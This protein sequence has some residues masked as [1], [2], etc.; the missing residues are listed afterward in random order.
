MSEYLA[1]INSDNGLVP[2]RCQPII[3]TNDD[4]LSTGPW[5]LISVTYESRYNSYHTREI[6]WKFMKFYQFVHVLN[7]LICKAQWL[8]WT[9]LLWFVTIRFYPVIIQYYFTGTGVNHHHSTDVI[10]SMMGSHITSLMIVYPTVYSGP[11]QR[12]HQSSTLLAFARGIHRSPVNFPHKGPVMWKM[13]PFDDVITMSISEA[14][15]IDMGEL[16]TGVHKDITWAVLAPVGL[17]SRGDEFKEAIFT[18]ISPCCLHH[19]F[20]WINLEPFY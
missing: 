14:T 6:I 1:I 11:D 15:L 3:W 18:I 4:L 10:M 16:I 17:A 13:F 19:C 8:L 20:N 5:E 9:V 2:L 12:K 7:F